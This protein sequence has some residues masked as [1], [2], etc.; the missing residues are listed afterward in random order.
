ME[1]R[2]TKINGR[3]YRSRLEARWAIFLEECL[4]FTIEYEPFDLPGWCS[5]FMIFG[6][7]RNILCEVKPHTEFEDFNVDLYA[8]C[9]IKDDNQYGLLLIGVKPWEIDGLCSIGWLLDDEWLGDKS[10]AFEDLAL[11]NHHDEKYGI[12][13]LHGSWS[14]RITGLYDGNLYYDP[15]DYDEMAP[16]W[17]KASNKVMWYR[18]KLRGV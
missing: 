8:K 14:D 15:A 7:K 13:G 11:I 17:V 9:I 12:V 6:K 10:L 2:A 3:I 4:N 18:E 5:D 1:A 16:L